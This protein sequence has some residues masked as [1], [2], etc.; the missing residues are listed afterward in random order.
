MIAM[1]SVKTLMN[2]FLDFVLFLSALEKGSFYSGI[3]RVMKLRSL[4]LEFFDDLMIEKLLHVL[5]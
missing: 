2:S 3:V 1:F 4:L 5:S